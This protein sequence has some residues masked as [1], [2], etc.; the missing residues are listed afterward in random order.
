MWVSNSG[1]DLDKE[2]LNI[3]QEIEELPEKPGLIIVDTLHRFLSGDENNAQDVKL[4]SDACA[5]IK[6][7][8][9]ASVLL[10]HHTGVSEESQHRGRGSSAWKGNMDVEIMVK[11]DA[12]GIYIKESKVK[13]GEELGPYALDLQGVP[14]NGLFDEDGDQVTS[15]VIVKGEAKADKED[16]AQARIIKIFKDA[17]YTGGM[18]LIQ[19]QPFVSRAYLEKYLVENKIY[20]AK[21]ASL[22]LKPSGPKFISELVNWGVIDVISGGFT[23]IDEEISSMMIMLKNSKVK[24]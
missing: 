8:T 10:V 16:Q 13:E 19:D 4:M 5:V 18:D 1:K 20:S 24:A 3:I 14:I 12:N 7:R 17:W 15:A 21:T 11:K 23:V 22:Y 2:Y 9:G 6:D